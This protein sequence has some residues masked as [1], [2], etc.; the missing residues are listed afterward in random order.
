MSEADRVC[1]AQTIYFEGR[2]QPLEG[3]KAIAAVVLNRVKSG[4]FPSTICGVVR[5][6]NRSGCQF[7][8][9]C[10]GRRD[11]PSDRAAWEAAR[12][13]AD[14]MI[15]GI[16]DD[17]TGGALFFH[18]HRM[19]RRWKQYVGKTLVLGDHLFYR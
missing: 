16:Y 5:Q 15:E 10:D 19:A 4:E 1:L 11:H 13:I 3:R 17:P 12:R 8:W 7:S 6:R 2:D 14:A 18:H 9:W